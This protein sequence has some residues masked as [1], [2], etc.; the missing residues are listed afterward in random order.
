MS[1]GFLSPVKST[2]VSW[3]SFSRMDSEDSAPPD[4]TA[5]SPK[6]PVK[7][8]ESNASWAMRAEMSTSV[9]HGSTSSEGHHGCARG[10]NLY[11]PMPTETSVCG[12]C[13]KGSGSS[14]DSRCGLGDKVLGTA[15][16]GST[17][18]GCRLSTISEES[19]VAKIKASFP[20]PMQKENPSLALANA[21]YMLMTSCSSDYINCGG[22]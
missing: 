14:A 8:S 19:S 6:R 22:D 4:S 11:S 10:H 9:R 16:I 7:R 1:L 2:N 5:T 18:V 20:V 12:L 13:D 21:G 15:E 3:I 17:S